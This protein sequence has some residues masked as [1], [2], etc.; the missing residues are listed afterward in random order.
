IEAS[1]QDAY[2]PV[3]YIY[4]FEPN[5][6]AFCLNLGANAERKVA[7]DK[8][9]IEHVPVATAPI[10]LAQETGKKR[11]I[12]LYM[13]VFDLE[14]DEALVGYSSGVLK[15]SG[16]LGE[17]VFQSRQS[18][19]YFNL[20]DVTEGERL[21][22]YEAAEQAHSNLPMHSY[23]AYFGT[24]KYHLEI[25][26][27]ENYVYGR[28][29][30]TSYVILTGGFVVATLFLVFVLTTT[31]QI[32]TVRRQVEL[33]TA[34]LS[35]A[36]S[37]ANAASDAKSA[38]LANMSHELR[39][40]LNAINGFLKLVL[41][42]ALTPVQKNYLQK[43]DLASVTLLGLINQTLNYA[44]IESGNMELEQSTVRMRSIARKMEALFGHIADESA[45]DFRIKLAND[46]PEV[47]IGDELRIE[48]I[49]LNLLSNAFKFTREGHIDLDISYEAD[50][51][52]LQIRVTDSGVGI[53]ADKMEHIFAAFGQ[54]DASISRRYG[55]SG[56][57]LSISRRIAIMMKGDI[58][59]RSTEGQG[60][61][62]LAYLHLPVGDAAV[63][64]VGAPESR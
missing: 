1:H 22:I 28:N 44:K 54:A 15:V 3:L 32:E 40:P 53:P 36:V 38:F 51:E 39:T 6:R 49:T 8:A 17:S 62:F 30:W 57:G 45:L 11:A 21:T 48:Q 50:D 59:V 23:D 7:L 10:V 5:R 42:T 64:D 4:P 29:D 27:A 55:G 34:E 60:S 58:L 2:Y 12:L 41:D 35:D 46:V 47:L 18:G 63:D 52:K 24:R 31:G 26:P 56:L 33:R 25:F 13:P 20:Y 9:A 61:E 19:L 37:R 14:D 43:A 16:I